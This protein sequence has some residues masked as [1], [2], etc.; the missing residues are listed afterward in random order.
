MCLATDI[1]EVFVVQEFIHAKGSKQ[2]LATIIVIT[3][4]RV[5]DKMAQFEAR[6]NTRR[7]YQFIRSDSTDKV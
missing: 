1:N 6:I 5:G 4:A 7:Y 2:L 3:L